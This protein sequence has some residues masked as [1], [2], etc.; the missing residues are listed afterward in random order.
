MTRP[1]PGAAPQEVPTD[2]AADGVP[3]SRTPVTLLT[4][5]LGSGKTT[6]VNRILSGT[7]GTRW[8]VLVNEFGELGI[9]DRLIVRGDE[10]LVELSN[11]CVCCT[12]RGD[13]VATLH[14]LRRR[15]FPWLRRRRIDRVLVETTGVA[16]PAPLLRTFL[17]EEG[18]AAAYRVDAVVCMVDAAHAD[19]ALAEPAAQ[20]Q[21]ALADLLLLN[22]ADLVDA[23]ALAASRESVAALNPLAEVHVVEQ[24]QVPLERVLRTHAARPLP[25]L[26]ARP[27]RG[28]DVQSV[29][30]R[31]ARPLDELQA[32]LWLDACVRTLGDRL[33]RCKGF[34]DLAGHPYRGV[35]Q[36]VYELYT[37]SAGAPWQ[38]GETRCS[39]V[40]FLGRDLDADFLQR[41][42]EAA[43][44]T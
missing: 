19:R 41:G 24:A 35:L 16:E 9:D 15:R 23:A 8:A 34:L 33:L 38:H 31:T 14:R 12:V 2:S 39:E 42:L 5:W 28:H 7:G 36:G 32:Q 43:I 4:G 1:T 17:V 30:V 13:L 40:V 20:E 10:D 3:D 27:R 29:V 26:E 22:K 18:V 6:L 21:V 25:E 11:G 44:A 37:V